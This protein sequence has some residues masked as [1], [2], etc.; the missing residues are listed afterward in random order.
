M[1]SGLSDSA[2]SVVQD[3]V[4]PPPPPPKTRMGISANAQARRS[5]MF[6][7]SVDPS[8]TG[9]VLSGSDSSSS[10]SSSSSTNV[11]RRASLASLYQARNANVKQSNRKMYDAVTVEEIKAQFQKQIETMLRSQERH[12]SRERVA[13]DE[14]PKVVPNLPPKVTT[15]SLRGA[16]HATVVANHKP[17]ERGRDLSRGKSFLEARSAV[18]QHIERMFASG[19]APAQPGRAA[20]PGLKHGMHGVSHA[21]PGQGGEDIPPPPPVHHGVEEAIRSIRG[22]GGGRWKSVESLAR[23]DEASSSSVSDMGEQRNRSDLTP[24]KFHSESNLTPQRLLVDI[25]VDGSS[26][27]GE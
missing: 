6:G 27:D 23:V 3:H 1:S 8:P 24:G 25:D 17:E 14:E 7:D 12:G 11:D 10:A 15:S 18:Q 20:P 9:S 26:D 13:A 4:A 22:S 16:T 5:R 21:L 19:E 2:Y